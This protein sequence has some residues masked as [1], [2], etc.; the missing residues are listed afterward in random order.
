MTDI[1]GSEGVLAYWSDQRRKGRG[2]Q[3]GKGPHTFEIL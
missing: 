2:G 3:L 1:F